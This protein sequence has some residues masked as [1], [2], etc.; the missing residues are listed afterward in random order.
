[1]SEQQQERRIGV[2]E[3]V[4]IAGSTIRDLYEGLTLNDLLLEEVRR[5]PGD[6]WLITMSFSLPR[7]ATGLG[8]VLP[9]GRALKQVRIDAKTGEFLDM[10]IRTLPRPPEQGSAPGFQPA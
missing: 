8:S 10:E 4:R 9:P 2:K 7:P 3:A 5:G 6:T 1:M